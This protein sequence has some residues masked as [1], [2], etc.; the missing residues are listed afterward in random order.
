MTNP[1]ILDDGKRNPLIIVSPDQVAAWLRSLADKAG[2][3][4]RESSAVQISIKLGSH[5]VVLNPDDQGEAHLNGVPE[6][7]LMVS[8]VPGGRQDPGPALADVVGARSMLELINR[9]GKAKRSGDTEEA[10]RLSDLTS[11]LEHEFPKAMA[12]IN[13][14][15]GDKGGD[16]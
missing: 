10:K 15:Y 4:D 11:Q 6:L 16:A 3:A 14:M 1:K 8:N 13:A 2:Y 9:F 7:V 12:L 5:S